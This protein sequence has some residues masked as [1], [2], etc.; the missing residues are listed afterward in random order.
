MTTKPRDA[1]PNDPFADLPL[2]ISVPRSADLLGI[3]R[4]AAYRFVTARLREFLETKADA[5]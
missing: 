2:L 4:A 5:A 1:N 3:S